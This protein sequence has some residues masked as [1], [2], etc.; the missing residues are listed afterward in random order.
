MGVNETE[1]AFG[2]ANHCLF[3]ALAVKFNKIL[4]KIKKD[5]L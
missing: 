1:Q 2:F 5:D 3:G 4:V